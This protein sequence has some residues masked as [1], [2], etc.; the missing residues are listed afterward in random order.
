MGR[1]LHDY[2]ERIESG[3]TRV[4]LLGIFATGLVAQFVKPVGDA[5]QDKAFLGG[6][7]LSLVGYVLYDAVREL[8]GTLQTAPVAVA[9]NSSDL[10]RHVREAFSGREEVGICFLGYTGETLFLELKHRL[11][12]LLREPGPTRKVTISILVPDFSVPM[13]V[14]ARVGPAGV[15]VDDPEFRRRLELKCQDFEQQLSG[16]QARLGAAGRVHVLCQY[17]QYQG[18]PRDK[19]C[20]FNG[21]LVFHGLYDVTA[22]QRH[23]GQD[24]QD[25][26]L[27]DPEGYGTDLT[28][29]SRKDG[30]ET[31]RVAIDT[32][33]KHF[34]GL[35]LLAAQPSWRVPPPPA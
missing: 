32:W 23:Q 29:W 4:L 8:S 18:I 17:R 30:T 35:W 3:V 6:A 25:R 27:Y 2:R 31:T 20:I 22:R 13:A 1:R 26:E 12:R 10:G 34:Q 9:V 33:V 11:E 28:V 16:L 19:I 14:P 5:L 24:R 15:P 21:E 7:L